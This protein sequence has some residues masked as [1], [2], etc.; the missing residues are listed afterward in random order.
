LGQPDTPYT[1]N[2]E[3]LGYPPWKG[4]FGTYATDCY[5]KGAGIDSRV[6]LGSYNPE[7]EGL[8]II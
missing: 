8:N 5:P 6:M 3:Y 7:R 2:L 1:Q 4:F